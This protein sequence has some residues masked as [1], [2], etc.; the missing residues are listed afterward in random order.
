MKAEEEIRYLRD[1]AI[2]LSSSELGAVNAYGWAERAVAYSKAL[3]VITGKDEEY[4]VLERAWR[5]AK[6]LRAKAEGR[7][8]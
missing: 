5:T 7:R 3:W 1:E 6:A 4:A 2:R 8:E